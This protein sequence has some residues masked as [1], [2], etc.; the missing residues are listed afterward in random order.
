MK[1]EARLPRMHAMHRL[2]SFATSRRA[3]TG[4]LLLWLCVLAAGVWAPV[5]RAHLQSQG[6]E[7]LCS[8]EVVAQWVPSPVGHAA[9]DDALGTALHH[10]IDCPLC[11]PVLAPPASAQAGGVHSLLTSAPA[12]QVQ[13]LQ[14]RTALHWPLP[15]GPPL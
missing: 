3:I 12:M 8:G 15:R 4:V 10:Q 5:A 6:L 1:A 7:R 14:V 11:M 2:P 13:A 9:H